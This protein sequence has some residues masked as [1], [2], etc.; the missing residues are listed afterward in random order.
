MSKS[1]V[2]DLSLGGLIKNKEL[3]T[4]YVDICRRN[5]RKVSDDLTAF[6]AETVRNH[7]EGNDQMKILSWFDNYDMRAVPM[8]MSQNEKFEDY[9]QKCDRTSFDSLKLKLVELNTLVHKT[10][11]PDTD[12]YYEHLSNFTN[13]IDK[14]IM[15]KSEKAYTKLFHAYNV[16]KYEENNKKKYLKEA[17]CDAWQ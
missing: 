2:C 9:F 4:K 1:W 10:V 8:I 17:G 3:W 13:C 12:N 16:K 5:N 14:D 7:E 6:I 15:E 11:R